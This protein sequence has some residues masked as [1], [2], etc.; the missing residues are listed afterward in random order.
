M[1]RVEC[2]VR[3]AGTCRQCHLRW[4]TLCQQDKEEC[5][6]CGVPLALTVDLGAGRAKSS[7]QRLRA[8]GVKGAEVTSVNM[9]RLGES[10]VEKV[11]DVRRRVTVDGKAA[12]PGESL[13]FLALIR[14]W[15]SE[16]RGKRRERLLHRTEGSIRKCGGGGHLLHPRSALCQRETNVSG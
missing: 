5:D 2:Q 9:H 16:V 10:F 11:S 6:V 4:C 14:G 1:C 12:A 7:T 13:E 15:H 3:Y 8:K